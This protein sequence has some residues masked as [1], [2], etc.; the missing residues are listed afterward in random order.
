MSKHCPNCNLIYEETEFFCQNDGSVLVSPN[1]SAETVIVKP[2]HMRSLGNPPITKQPNL[3][4]IYGV[5]LLLSIV[6]VGFGTAYFSISKVSENTQNNKES[7]NSTRKIADK[8]LET[9]SE[10]TVEAVKNLLQ[11]WEAAQDTQSFS[12]YR[13]CYT[14]PFKGIKTTDK[15]D[16]VY[17]SGGWMADRRKMLQTAVGLD[18]EIKNLDITIA[19]DSAT[20]T[21]DQYYR[22]LRYSDRGPKELKIKQTPSGAKIFYENLKASYPVK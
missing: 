13:D 17:D 4:L 20:A 12:A 7:G 2:P 21:F 16:T 1:Q 10:L 9:K 22:S 15:G 14:S 18:I 3:H 19:G 5:V 11:K 6:A 8:E